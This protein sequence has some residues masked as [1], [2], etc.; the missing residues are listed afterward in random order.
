MIGNTLYASRTTRRR[1][2]A[3]R[4]RRFFRPLAEKLEQRVLLAVD[5]FPVTEATLT[6][7]IGADAGTVEVVQLAG[8]ATIVRDD[9]PADDVGANSL[10][11]IGFEVQD[12]N[13]TG[14]STSLG[15]LTLQLA[16]AG[17]PTLG[18]AEES[19][20]IVPN[21][22]E[23][24]IFSL[25]GAFVE[26]VAGNVRGVHNLPISLQAQLTQLPPA[27][28]E[29]YQFNGSIPLV[30]PVNRQPI[31]LTIQQLDLVVV[32]EELFVEEDVLPDT[33]ALVELVGGPLGD[34]P[35]TFI[36]NGT[37]ETHVFFDGAVE[38]SALDN[39]PT[40]GFDEVTT[41]LVALNL[42]DG[43]VRLTESPTRVSRGVMTELANN[44]PGTLDVRP[45]APQ[46]SVTSSFDVFFEVEVEGLLVHNETPI[47]LATVI[48]EKPP[49]RRYAAQLD[50]PLELLDANNNPTGISLLKVVHSTGKVEIDS[51]PETVGQVL[52]ETPDPPIVVTPNSDLPP[53]EAAYLA[54]RQLPAQYSAPGAQLMLQD[55]RYRLLADPPPTVV[56]EGD[57]ERVT[58]EST[59]EGTALFNGGDPVPVQLRGLLELVTRG[60]AGQTTGSWETEIVSIDLRGDI[61]GGPAVILRESPEMVSAGRSSVAALDGDFRVDSFFD[62]WTEVSVDGGASFIPAAA[63]TRVDAFPIG[64][65]TDTPQVP[66]LVGSH[67]TAAQEGLEFTTGNLRV[68]LEDLRQKVQL[69]VDRQ[70]SGNN[71]IEV[72]DATVQALATV[73]GGPFN[74]LTRVVDFTGQ[75]QTVAFDKV[76]NTT[77]TFQTEI[78]S[79]DLQGNIGGVSMML[80]ESSAQPSNG[81]VTIR[82]LGDG[83]YHVGSFFDIFTELSI[84]GAG[85]LPAEAGARV[86]LR[87]DP[88][89]ELIA[90]VGQ[91]AIAVHFEGPN[92]GDA[93]DEVLDGFRRD[94]VPTEII[95]L[96]LHGTTAA[97]PVHIVQRPGFSSPGQIEE[98]NVNDRPGLLQVAPFDTRSGQTAFSTFFVWPQFHVAGQPMVTREPLFLQ[99]IITHKPPIEQERYENPNPPRVPLFDEVTGEF[100]GLYVLKEI[101]QTSSTIEHDIFPNTVGQLLLDVQGT[102]VLVSAVGPTQ[103]DVLFEGT[104]EGVAIDDDENGLDEV[105]AQ[106]VDL[107]L[108]GPTPWGPLNITLDPAIPSLGRI[109]EQVNNNQRL[110]D[111]DPFAPGSADSFFDVAFVVELN[112]RR[113]APARPTR[114]ETVIGH[115][116]P[117]SGERYLFAPPQPVELFDVQ[118]GQPTGI[119]IIREIHDPATAI[120]VDELSTV[121]NLLLEVPPEPGVDTPLATLPAI[122]SVYHAP[123]PVLFPSPQPVAVENIQLMPMSDPGPVIA[124]E[125]SDE[126]AS[127]E[128]QLRGTAV[129]A[130][131][132][133]E[134]ELRGPVEII[135]RGKAG[136]T[137]GSWE[138]EIVS[139]D[140]RGSIP[141]GP[142]LLIRESPSIQSLG[143]ASIRDAGDGRF[144]IDSFFDVFTEASLDDSQIWIASAGSTRLDAFDT[145]VETTSELPPNRG[146]YRAP[147]QVAAEF[148]SPLVQLVL[149]DIRKRPGAVQSREVSGNDEIVTYDTTLTAIATVPGGV[150]EAV[151]LSGQVRSMA[152]DKAIREA[153]TFQTEILSMDLRGTIA[154]LPVILRESPT[155]ASTGEAT[156]VALP[157]GNFQVDS[158]FDVFPEV[159]IDGG[160]A[161]VPSVGGARLELEEPLQRVLV[162]G[163]GPTT[164]HVYFEGANEGDAVDDDE[165][166]FEEVVAQ[167]A[168]LALYASTP[169]GPAQ[170]TLN[171]AVPSLGR[172]EELVNNTPNRLDIDPFHPGDA[173]SYFDVAFQIQLG[174]QTLVPLTTTTRLET[175]I[176]HKPPVNGERYRFNPPAPIPLIDPATG[177]RTGFSV[178]REIHQVAGV[179]EHDLFAN[180]IGQILLDVQ[181]TPVLV[182]AVGPTQVDVFFEGANEGDALDDDDD[183]LDE[184]VAEV[185]QLDL[186]GPTPLG[187]V[188]VRL[189]PDRRSLG[190]ITELVNNTPGRLDVDPFAE[191][192]ANSYFDMSFIVELNGRELVPARATRVET[193][194]GHKPPGDGERYLFAPTDPVQLLDR[195]TGEPSGIFVVRELHDVAPTVE[196]DVFATATDEWTLEL[197]RSPSVAAA[198]PNLPPRG[199]Y[200]SAPDATV[201]FPA[202]EEVLLEDVRFRP[203]LEPAPT[204]AITGADER[205]TFESSLRATAIIGGRPLPV[206]LQGAVEVIYRGKA[207]QTTG[208]FETEILSMDLRGQTPEGQ[209]VVVRESAAQTSTG[210]TTVVDLGGQNY[211]VDSFI[212]NWM[213]IAIEGGDF[214][215]S[216]DSL[217]VD[218]F[219]AGVI[220]AGPELP[221]GD[222]IYRSGPNAFAE[223]PGPRHII[224]EDLRHQPLEV[225]E[226]RAAGP[227][228]LQ[229]IDASLTAIA[230]IDGAMVPVELQGSVE[231]IV[232]NKVGRE[233]GSFDTEIVSMS[234][235]GD[236]NGLPVTLQESP[237]QSSAG[238]TIVTDRGGSFHVDSFFDIFVELSVDGSQFTPATRAVQL[239]LE[240]LRPEIV[241][242]ATGSATLEVYFEGGTEGDATDDDG[243]GRD[244]V[245]TQFTSLELT[246]S[247]SL[248]QVNATLNAAVPSLGKIEELNNDSPGRLDIDPFAPGDANSSFYRAIELNVAGQ[249][250]IPRTITTHLEAVI[251]DKPPAS[252]EL[253]EFNPAVPIPLIDPATGR[254]TGYSLVRETHQFNEATPFQVTSLEPNLTGF[255]AEFSNDI[256]ASLLNLYDSLLISLGPADVTLVGQTVGPVAGTVTVDPAD[257]AIAFIKTGG[258]LEPDTYTATLRSATDGFVDVD[259][260]LLDGDGD[261]TAGDDFMQ[262]FVVAAP[263]VNTVTLGLP[264]VV[265]G[266]GQD[267]N[268]PANETTGL[269]VTLSD[270]SGVRT[271]AFQLAYD[272]ALLQ[273]L[274]AT[275]GP[276]LPAAATLTADTTV[277]GNATV[278]IVSPVDLPA[279]SNTL[280]NFQARVP[281]ANAEA[282]YNSKQ[283]LDIHSVRVGGADSTVFPA[284]DDDAVHLVGYL[285]EASGN[286]RLNASDAARVATVA[287]QIDS[288]FPAYQLADP[289]LIG[290]VSRNGRLNAFDASLVAR[291]A[292]LIPVPEVPPIPVGLVR[293]PN[294]G[295][296]PVLSIPRTLAAVGGSSV[297]VPLHIESTVDL[298][299]PHR[300][301][302]ADA[303]VMFDTEVVTAVSVTPGG[304]ITGH[305]GWTF[306]ASIDNELGRIVIVALGSRPVSGTF[307]QTLV[308]LH[309]EV[310]SS[311]AV[312]PTALNL[313]AMS[314]GVY[315]A[316]V[317]EDDS[318]LP[319]EGPVTDRP[320]DRIDG[321]L[322]VIPAGGGQFDSLDSLP[323]SLLGDV[324]HDFPRPLH[325]DRDT[326]PLSETMFS[327]LD[328][329]VNVKTI[330][331]SGEHRGVVS[332]EAELV[333][334]LLAEE[335]V[336]SDLLE[337]LDVLNPNYS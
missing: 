168:D 254:P 114:V 213:E 120:E 314:D 31:N 99:S 103:F 232:F 182:A 150:P 75:M 52:L 3:E 109:E 220:A 214:L 241:V 243:D 107:R 179:I 98:I 90:T 233:T 202:A 10:E 15:P 160:Q 208:T 85:F 68:T 124:L 294:G 236:L 311:A 113:M 307:S 115:K 82:D 60:N 173:N 199:V 326:P 51:F 211:R 110:L 118:T 18:F 204:I 257:R 19:V 261:G 197:P 203:V 313:V 223:F 128:A 106:M 146:E 42:T 185:V 300:L 310:A 147:A 36:L 227:N 72:F 70:V 191:G 291:V 111:V 320:N 319:L 91:A 207:G 206:T 30:D 308:D 265:R 292:A 133:V 222:G 255:R 41:E 285:G 318:L 235:T 262:S 162:S 196:T 16:P 231:R 180:S 34:I 170:I 324:L 159:S 181:G 132:S 21:Q 302:E 169:L 100:T 263:P 108:S 77:G 78:L 297:A 286:G 1:P 40:D 304:F 4:E 96:D 93:S 205:V 122:G 35:Q 316:L 267:V 27:P 251:L 187:T 153:G 48:Y 268:I 215:P 178:V 327:S 129:F 64:V 87:P 151:E 334:R 94:E 221:P 88:P 216:A 219:N 57:D 246:G 74:D 38:G 20:N 142:V 333:D 9:V 17:P 28:G 322:T 145:G 328:V 130:G 164:A 161:F 229:V 212:H 123:L 201:V 92:E 163:V 76:G 272:P 56:V 312:G 13:L 290:D 138:T 289:S 277:A 260:I 259:G 65:V 140:L 218:A 134:V 26:L 53:L 155:L 149:E 86:E 116:P 228:E 239:D 293:T 63:S 295:P 158:F 271:V 2:R 249:A 6:L 174:G 141:G 71:E 84:D 256:N 7:Q 331:T 299:F 54:G 281:E 193:V 81:A 321:V 119:F 244:E 25:A 156:I 287:A 194:I 167:I 144:R 274:G 301:A 121:G 305:P 102:Q 315:T 101:H 264:D 230:Q 137:T 58:L 127:F 284:I 225:V 298:Q 8:P 166:G 39:D 29:A 288:G 43:N 79:L 273:I 189:N 61:P 280:V 253:Y 32:P 172:I 279:G 250:L 66:S 188:H 73:S 242:A 95:S 237:S 14:V 12:L 152:I 303:V 117:G 269:P 240:V 139:M 165:N 50:E 184:V 126:R 83:A 104:T 323:A 176:E 46:G 252:G 247:T 266:P 224:L 171:P 306:T 49:F 67:R 135:S 62:I 217:R 177:R 89:T 37:T 234:L 192:D 200:L 209:A 317:A 198:E 143:Q 125:G 226:R 105:V 296:D 270:G 5:V 11:D 23:A 183:G 112:G 309:F 59:L 33:T 44:V 80:R 336:L 245:V 175:V 131:Q 22:L 325:G 69:V 45:F 157:D 332:T 283:I 278:T 190:E 330:D 24:P 248:G 282:I 186:V 47:S 210:Q 258:P 337:D 97:G 154:G 238:K 335:D 276:S 148:L 275:V 329:S 195:V 136:Q 55:I